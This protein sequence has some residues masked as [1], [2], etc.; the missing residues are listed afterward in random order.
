MATRATGRLSSRLTL[1]PLLSAW[2]VLLLVVTA[3]S[4]S[5]IHTTDEAQT[6]P[7]PEE[8]SSEPDGADAGHDE[9]PLDVVRFVR[10]LQRLYTGP[11]SPSGGGS[12]FSP[13]KK[14]SS[15]EYRI[16]HRIAELVQG[17]E[18]KDMGLLLIVLLRDQHERVRLSA[19]WA[20]SMQ[21]SC[22]VYVGHAQR[23]PL[24]AY[25]DAMAWWEENEHKLKWDPDFKKFRVRKP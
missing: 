14:G 19:H 9:D 3:C 5:R 22:P 24:R 7:V 12:Y 1:Y 18:D 25:G 13:G 17:P 10:L 16:S 20:L 15:G 6:L 23:E 4:S 8:S 21:F 2:F 11:D